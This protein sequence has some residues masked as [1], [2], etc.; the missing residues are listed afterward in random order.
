M[1]KAPKAKEAW[2]LRTGDGEDIRLRE[3]LPVLLGLFTYSPW[4]KGV[5]KNDQMVHQCLHMTFRQD[6]IFRHRKN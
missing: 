3:G 5:T 2:A 1:G 6:L 4:L